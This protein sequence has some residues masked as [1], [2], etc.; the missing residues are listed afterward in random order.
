MMRSLRFTF[1]GVAALA[2]LAAACGNNDDALEP[3][4]ASASAFAGVSASEPA[5]EITSDSTPLSESEPA[6]NTI[7]HTF[8]ETVI[9]ACPQ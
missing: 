3:E 9:G 5:T 4:S 6:V 2:L 1:V 7:I 8:G